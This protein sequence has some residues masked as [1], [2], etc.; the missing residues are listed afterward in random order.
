MICN[1][2]DNNNNDN[3]NNNNNSNNNNKNSMT[4]SLKVPDLLVWL[5]VDT[6]P[7]TRY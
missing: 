6:H 3:N 2:H 7:L 5:L 1:N 4:L